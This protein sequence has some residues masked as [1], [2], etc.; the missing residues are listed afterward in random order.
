VDLWRTWNEGYG[1]GNVARWFSACSE[2]VTRCADVVD[3]APSTCST[4]F[5]RTTL[6]GRQKNG[7]IFT[8]YLV[9]GG[10]VTKGQG[11]VREMVRV[12]EWA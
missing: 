9:Q 11:V 7:G 2:N 3:L 4:S 6:A 12:S 5:C 1:G 8:V 10:V